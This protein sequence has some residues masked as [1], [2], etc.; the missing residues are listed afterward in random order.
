MSK[1]NSHAHNT[2]Y[3]TQFPSSHGACMGTK[4]S[5]LLTPTHF[6]MVVESLTVESFTVESL[7]VESLTVEIFMIESL[8][9]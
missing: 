2:N 1:A 7:Q 9:G 6:V 5:L 3:C 4:L 8:Y